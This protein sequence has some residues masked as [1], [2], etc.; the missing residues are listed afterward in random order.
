MPPMK[1]KKGRNSHKQKLPGILLIFLFLLGLL[2][3]SGCH[4]SPPKVAT[5][6]FAAE[7]TLQRIPITGDIRQAKSELSGLA[8]YGET[9]ILLPQYPQRFPASHDGSLFAIPKAEILAYLAGEIEGTITPEEVSLEAPGLYERIPGFEGFEAIAIAGD[10]VYLTIESRPGDSMLGYVVTGAITPGRIAIDV[11]SLRPIE[12]QADLDNFSDEALL[13]YGGTVLTFYEAWGSRVNP[14]PVAH[15]F[16]ARLNP[17][18]RWPLPNIEYRITDVTDVDE[19]GRFWAINYLYPGDIEKLELADDPLSRQYGQGASHAGSEVVE[20]LVEFHIL[21][22][23]VVLTQTAP[24]QLLLAA[25]GEARNWEGI[26]RLDGV[27]FLLVTDRY[28]ETILGFV[29]YP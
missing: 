8:W 6:D 19:S 9:L 27:G 13:I 16:D 23:K 7:V 11:E 29:A 20:R 4:N 1:R 14:E 22:E 21:D 17:G 28:P 15:T 12:P 5:R 18:S 2:S 10:R 24:I 25:D 26:V 3:L